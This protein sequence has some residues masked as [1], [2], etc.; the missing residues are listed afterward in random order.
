MTLCHCSGV[1]SSASA[2]AEMPALLTRISS[3]AE[4]LHGAIDHGL[5]ILHLGCVG[6]NGKTRGRIARDRAPPPAAGRCRAPQ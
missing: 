5:D 1:M 2:T 3:L 6:L 4:F